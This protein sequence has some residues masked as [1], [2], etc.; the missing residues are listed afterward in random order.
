MKRTAKNSWHYNGGTITAT[1]YGT[2][3][4][5]YRRN[6]QTVRECHKTISEAKAWLEAISNDT[7]TLSPA[8]VRDALSA[9]DILPEGVTLQE[10]AEFYIAHHTSADDGVTFASS[11]DAYL[12]QRA[13]EL[14]AR[15]LQGY[16]QVL[17][18]AVEDLPE[19]LKLQDRK[20]VGRERV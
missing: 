10:V 2:F 12:D 20:S 15:T 6:G 13:T 19:H 7:P 5:Y 18:R 17:L 11:V 4:A 1:E 9:L 8:R 14:R 3:R 16:R